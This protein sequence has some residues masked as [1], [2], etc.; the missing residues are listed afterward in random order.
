MT[1][2][3]LKFRAWDKVGKRWMQ[4]ELTRDFLTIGVPDDPKTGVFTIHDYRT[5]RIEIVQYTGFTDAGGEELYSGDIFEDDAEW[6]SVGWSEDD[7]AWYAF[8]IRDRGGNVDMQLSEFAGSSTCWKQ[9]SVFENP[10]LLE[11]PDD[12]E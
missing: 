5:N 12:A 11:K 1:N 2:K 7:G 9:G 4:D 10:E 8:G 3:I 6:F